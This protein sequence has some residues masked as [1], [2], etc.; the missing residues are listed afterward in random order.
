MPSQEISWIKTLVAV[1]SLSDISLD[2]VHCMYF[3]TLIKGK[4][5]LFGFYCFLLVCVQGS[6]EITCLMNLINT[7]HDIDFDEKRFESWSFFVD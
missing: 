3:I 5:L 6:R 4:F 1:F 7:Q 2:C